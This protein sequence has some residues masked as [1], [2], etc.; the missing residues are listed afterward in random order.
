MAAEF[1]VKANNGKKADLYAKPPSGSLWS[2]CG[3]DLAPCGGAVPKADCRVH[4]DHP[5][6]FVKKMYGHFSTSCPGGVR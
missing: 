5:T 1:H 2:P 6:V 3:C 4:G